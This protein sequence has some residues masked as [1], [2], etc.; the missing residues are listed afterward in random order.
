MNKI[1]VVVACTILYSNIVV[2]AEESKP[3]AP[4]ADSELH[5][6][7]KKAVAETVVAPEAPSFKDVL[8]SPTEESVKNIL[9]EDA[10]QDK[11]NRGTPRGSILSLGAALESWGC[12][13][14]SF[15]RL[16]VR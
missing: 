6:S 9:P 5:E 12:G 15:G 4:K 16:I 14:P 11:F 13:R 8:A 10:P 2:S 3:V 7:D 1:I